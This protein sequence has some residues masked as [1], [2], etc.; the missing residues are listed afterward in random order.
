VLAGPGERQ[1]VGGSRVLCAGRRFGVR[2]V[3]QDW[4][5][6]AGGGENSPQCGGVRCEKRRV[7]DGF[8]RKIFFRVGE[9][10]PARSRW[11][12]GLIGGRE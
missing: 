1:V 2:P 12:A 4:R 3:A 9:I 10:S 6:F 5:E 11:A 8:R 7:F